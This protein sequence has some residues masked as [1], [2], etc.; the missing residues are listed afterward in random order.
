MEEVSI[1]GFPQNHLNRGHWTKYTEQVQLDLDTQPSLVSLL[2]YQR[3][4]MSWWLSA[5]W[6]DTADDEEAIVQ[7]V[8]TTNLI[9]VF[10]VVSHTFGVR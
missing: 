10:Q 8:V 9:A 3:V 1:V 6:K 4:V 7:A 2:N 5:S